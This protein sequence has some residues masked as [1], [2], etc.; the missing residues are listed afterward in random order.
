MS[1][2]QAAAQVKQFTNET[3]LNLTGFE[4]RFKDVFELDERDRN[5]V[6]THLFIS[7]GVPGADSECL[8]SVGVDMVCNEESIDRFSRVSVIPGHDIRYMTAHRFTLGGQ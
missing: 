2:P 4:Q 8:R 7:T 5:D 6:Q 3:G 1:R